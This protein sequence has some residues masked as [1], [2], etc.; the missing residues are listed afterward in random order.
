MTIE[1]MRQ[2]STLVFRLNPYN[3]REVDCKQNR[4][5]ARWRRYESYATRELAEAALLQ[6]EKGAGAVVAQ[7][8]TPV[9]LIPPAI[10]AELI[11]ALDELDTAFGGRTAESANARAWVEAHG[12][13]PVTDEGGKP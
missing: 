4:H 10:Y 9:P 2:D 12:L 6:L 8:V 5:G 11:E 7:P 3:S 1:I 13:R